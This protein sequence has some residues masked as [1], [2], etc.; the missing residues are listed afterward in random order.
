M[1]TLALWWFGG[2]AFLKADVQGENS[3]AKE[4]SPWNPLSEN[5]HM[6]AAQ[7]CSCKSLGCPHTRCFAQP[8]GLH[9]FRRVSTVLRVISDIPSSTYAGQY[10][11]MLEFFGKGPG[12]PFL[13]KKGF[14]GMPLPSLRPFPSSRRLLHHCPCGADIRADS[15]AAADRLVYSGLIDV[16]I[17]SEARAPENSGAQPITAAILAKTFGR[18]YADFVSFG[19]LLSA[20]QSAFLPEYEH[21]SSIL[22]E[23][24]VDGRCRLFQIKRVFDDCFQA[25]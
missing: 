18:I 8:K 25:Q 11:I 15:A 10:I 9:F 3:F 19:G 12:N 22:L 5:S 21:L 23:H 14:P 6:I 4:F 17:P 24:V 16:R 20:Y 13:Q 2:L 1:I 7:L